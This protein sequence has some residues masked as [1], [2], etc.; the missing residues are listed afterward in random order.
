MLRVWKTEGYFEGEHIRSV[1]F[2]MAVCV[3]TD[4]GHDALCLFVCFPHC[5]QH[6]LVA[7][8]LKE[9][10]SRNCPENKGA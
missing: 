3:L 5:A 2:A 4:H 10:T 8:S 1:L 6:A 7:Y 9:R